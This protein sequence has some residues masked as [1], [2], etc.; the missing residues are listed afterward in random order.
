M[1]AVAKAVTPI[2]PSAMRLVSI[3]EKQIVQAG[4]HQLKRPVQPTSW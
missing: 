4:C 2:A 3:L 1:H